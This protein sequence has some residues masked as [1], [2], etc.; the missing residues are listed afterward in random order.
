MQECIGKPLG[1]FT[2]NASTPT[3]PG[4]SGCRKGEKQSHRGTVPLCD[5][6]LLINGFNYLK[7]HS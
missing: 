6:F 1:L 7:P 4:Q 2:H 5:L 3:E